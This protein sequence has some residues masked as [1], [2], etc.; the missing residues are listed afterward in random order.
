MSNLKTV[1]IVL[2]LLLLGV[3]AVLPLAAQNTPVAGSLISVNFQEAL[4][5]VEVDRA[6]E[7]LFEWFERPRS[8]HG[9]RVL[10]VRFWSRDFDGTPIEALS[11]VYIP[12]LSGTTR[13]APVLSFLSGTTGVGDQC[14]PSLEQPEVIRWGWYRQNMMAYAA[15]GVI[16]VF[17]DYL[18]FNNPDI[19]QRYFSAA[20]EGHL[21]LDSLRAVRRVFTEYP[22][23]I[24][25]SVR[26]GESSFTAGYSQGGHAALAAADMNRSY[27]PEIR[28]DGAIAFGTTNSVEVLMKEAAYYTPYILLSYRWMY[29]DEVIRYEDLLQP[30]WIP[31][32]EADVMGMCVDQFQTFFPFVGTQLYTPEFYSA[33][34]NNRLESE[35]PLLKEVLDANETG[36]S[37]HGKPVLVFQG[38]QDI[39]VTNPA[40]RRYVERL[41]ASG[42][43]VEYIE[44]DG[45]RHR[46]TRPA[47][48]A[49]SLAFMRRHS[50]VPLP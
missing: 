12:V 30:Q 38:N 49:A 47:G 13:E 18:G 9:V 50:A 1:R 39:I 45:V 24:R 28:L 6:A 41:R 15:Q 19:P 36:L 5:A 7:P 17:P 8:R 22:H 44:M 35:F 43:E 10:E 4:T 48:F 27:A 16:T 14:A 40:Q 11:T 32:L 42:S 25:S 37:G 26:P 46:H 3:V 21:M 33:L 29:G 20:A 2:S 31:T 34:H 23:L